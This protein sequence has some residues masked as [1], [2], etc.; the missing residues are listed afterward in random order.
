VA[1]KLFRER[2]GSDCPLSAR[3]TSWS[4]LASRSTR[5]YREA[6]PSARPV[7]GDSSVD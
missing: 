3:V 6:H 1:H 2:I 7:C 5:L 4:K